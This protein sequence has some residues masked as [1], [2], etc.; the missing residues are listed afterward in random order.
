[1]RTDAD[2]GT[3]PGAVPRPEPDRAS[4]QLCDTIVRVLDRDHALRRAYLRNRW[5]GSSTWRRNERGDTAAQLE[6][7]GRVRQCD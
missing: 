6:S 5:R 4:R 7:R 2:P 3:I 1:M